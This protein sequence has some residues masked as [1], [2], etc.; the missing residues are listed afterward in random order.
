[1]TQTL[2]KLLTFAEF[3]AW[4]PDQ[5]RYEL[6]NGVIVPMNPPVGFHEMA[7]ISYNSPR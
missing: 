1:M 2:P 3:V 5:G 6:H 7:K 4:L